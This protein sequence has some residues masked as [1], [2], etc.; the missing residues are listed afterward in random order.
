MQFLNRDGLILL[1]NIVPVLPGKQVP[2]CI[3]IKREFHNNAATTEKDQFCFV[4]FWASLMMTM[5]S[6][7]V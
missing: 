5:C 6:I 3:S 7:S 2:S 1:C 4:D